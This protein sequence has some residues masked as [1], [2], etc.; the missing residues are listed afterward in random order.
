MRYG[1]A[2]AHATRVYS[3][4]SKFTRIQHHSDLLSAG[5]TAGIDVVYRAETNLHFDA[6]LGRTVPG[7][8]SSRVS[9]G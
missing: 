9:R 1:P 8:A 3:Q 6:D 4:R 7:D 5:S 2:E